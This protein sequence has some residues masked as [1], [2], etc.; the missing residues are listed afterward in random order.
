M[1]LGLI[2]TDPLAAVVPPLP[3]TLLAAA[4]AGHD[5]SAGAMLLPGLLA[6]TV[7][8]L[9]TIAAGVGTYLLLP[10]RRLNVSARAVGGVIMLFAGLVLALGIIRTTASLAGG[11]GIYFWIFSAIA[12]LG[13]LRVVTH[14]RPVYAALYFVLTVFATAGL[15]I[16]MWAEF[17]AA[18]LVLIYAGAI[19]VTYVFVIMLAASSTPGGVEKVNEYDAVSRDP[20]IASAVGVALMGVIL[21]VIFDRAE[22]VSTGPRSYTY[23]ATKTSGDRTVEV[24]GEV[25]APS[26]ALARERIPEGL[27]ITGDLHEA[28]SVQALGRYF[29]ANHAVTLELAG[30][31]LT[32]GM[33]GAIM[34][35]RRRVLASPAEVPAPASMTGPATPI[36]DDPFSI[37]VYGTDNPRQKAY[38]ET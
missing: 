24:V 22:R 35:A 31:L 38:P 17:M 16:L 1:T 13:A 21:F 26:P 33:I 28:F 27:T 4:A 10:N 34:I 37:P 30:L 14:P 9:L 23:V 36:S 5:T 25:S 6:P 19:L 20:L 8:L 2:A 18:A 29:F 32:I 7:V 3:Q 12:L 15:F 11:P